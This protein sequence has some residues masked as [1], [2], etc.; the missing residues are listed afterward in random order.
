MLS[1]AASADCTLL[2]TASSALRCSVS[3]SNRC[4][5]S[6][7][8]AFSR[9][10]PISPT[11]VCSNRISSGPKAYSRSKL[12]TTTTPT[13]RS[14]TMILAV[15][16]ESEHS[17]PGATPAAATSAAVLRTMTLRSEM[18]SFQRASGGVTGAIV[19]RVP[20]SIS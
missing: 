17:V 3:L 19:T 13:T 12:S 7:S 2:I 10:T 11:I 5:S 8:R 9:A 15:T 20:C 6:N 14:P 18:T 1:S 16:L 4:V